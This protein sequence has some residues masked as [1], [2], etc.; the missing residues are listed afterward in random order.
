[1]VDESGESPWLFIRYAAAAEHML[2]DVLVMPSNF[3]AA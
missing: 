2:E 1:M 3:I